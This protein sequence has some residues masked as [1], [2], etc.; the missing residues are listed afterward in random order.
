M[1]LQL[2]FSGLFILA[3]EPTMPRLQ[4]KPEQYFVYICYHATI[5][6]IAGGG[7]C[8]ISIDTCKWECLTCMLPILLDLWYL[9]R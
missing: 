8:A 3:Y 2:L 1:L 4:T 9:V 6:L 7:E 5:F